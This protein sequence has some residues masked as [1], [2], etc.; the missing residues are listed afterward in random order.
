MATAPVIDTDAVASEV[1]ALRDRIVTLRVYGD[2]EASDEL[3][4]EAETVISNGLK[5][6]KADVVSLRKTLREAVSEAMSTMPPADA[7]IEP[8]TVASLPW[9]DALVHKGA[10]TVRLVAETK[11]RGGRQLAQIMLDMRR[12]IQDKDGNPDLKGTSNLAKVAS[13]QVYSAV[14]DTL[15][16]T[17]TELRA[18]VEK[19]QNETR[20]AMADARVV[21]ARALDAEDNEDRALYNLIPRAEGQS[22]SEAVAE[23]YSFKLQTRAEIEA[24]RRERKALEAASAKGGDDSAESDDTRLIPDSMSDAL[25]QIVSRVSVAVEL[26]GIPDLAAAVEAHEI[27][28]DEVRVRA[29]EIEALISQLSELHAALI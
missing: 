9:L 14:T 12:R 2:F 10:D 22:L 15:T 24:E 6:R 13:S 28:D 19:L 29:A 4:H 16:E 23:H 18:A 20:L 26:I 11:V 1:Y 27:P 8:V 21:Y 5:G 7:E 25:V 17:D 3:K